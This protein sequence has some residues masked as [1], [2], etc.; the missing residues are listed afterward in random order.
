MSNQII[1][2]SQEPSPFQSN[3]QSFLLDNDVSF[4]PDP[5]HYKAIIRLYNLRLNKDKNKEIQKSISPIRKSIYSSLLYHP[6]ANNDI[7]EKQKN[8]REE[9]EKIKK[10]KK[11]NKDRQQSN[12]KSIRSQDKKKSRTVRRI[13]GSVYERL[14]NGK[15][16]QSSLEKEN[17]KNKS[18]KLTSR[19]VKEGSSNLDVYQNGFGFFNKSSGEIK[20]QN[21]NSNEVESAFEKMCELKQKNIKELKKEDILSPT[22]LSTHSSFCCPSKFIKNPSLLIKNYE[23][24]KLCLSKIEQDS[25]LS[26]DRKEKVTKMEMKQN[27]L[28]KGKETRFPG[29]GGLSTMESIQYYDFILNKAKVIYKK[30]L[31]K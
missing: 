31:N 5:P 17:K 27:I 26:I 28:E 10:V 16:Y 29:M 18:V 14:V 8:R 30:Y 19:E 2:P 22:P 24:E 9:N 23:T 12:E 13:R 21:H 6:K 7:L 25:Y 20:N 1:I 3:L 11:K 4:V 15:M